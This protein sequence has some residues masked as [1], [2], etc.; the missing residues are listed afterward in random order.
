LVRGLTDNL[1]DSISSVMTGNTDAAKC[2]KTDAAFL[3][4]K[5]D[6]AFTA[7]QAIT[8]FIGGI[9][10]AGDPV[11][12]DKKARASLFAGSG[13]AAPGIVAASMLLLY[14]FGMAMFDPC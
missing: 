3:G 1:N 11:L 2:L 13:A 12:E 8:T 6:R 7:T 9:D 4:C 5:V 14:K 10:T